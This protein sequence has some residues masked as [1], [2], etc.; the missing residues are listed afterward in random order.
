MPSL[1]RTLDAE[2]RASRARAVRA[3]LRSP[4][5]TDTHNDFHLVR[6]HAQWLQEY[7]NDMCGWPLTVDTRRGFARL[8][9]ITGLTDQHRPAM[10]DRSDTRPFNLRRYVLFCTLCAVLQTGGPQTTLQELAHSVTGLTAD[11]EILEPFD[12]TTQ[13]ERRALVDAARLLLQLG[14][15]KEQDSEGDYIASGVGN[16]LFDVDV[17]RL[18]HVLVTPRPPSASNSPEEML[19]EDRYGPQ[20]T[21]ENYEAGADTVTDE[22]RASRLRHIIM[23][24][25]LDDPVVYFDSLRQEELAYLKSAESTLREGVEAAG[26]TLEC[27]MEGWLCVDP[28]AWSTDIVFPGPDSTVKHA[29]LLL[30]DELVETARTRQ[31]YDLR[32]TTGET[33]AF[34]EDLMQRFPTWAR[35]YQSAKSGPD[36]LTS[37]ALMLLASM[38]LVS[39]D[40]D[41]VFVRPAIARFSATLTT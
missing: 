36:R 22:Q 27:R 25:L 5:L 6:V 35:T 2:I 12:V 34:I 29:A 21:I 17:R 19:H 15:L 32:I 16:I 1:D 20:V 28:Q 10:T 41:T 40:E 14:V 8:R 9:K 11:D 26:F 24:R 23:R 33:A 13:V 38:H 30:A 7:F 4:L 31:Q 3:L 37:E 18:S 39:L